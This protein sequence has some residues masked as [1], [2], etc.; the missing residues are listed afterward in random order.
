LGYRGMKEYTLSFDGF[1][2]PRTGLLGGVEGKGFKQLMATFESARI[3]T[4]ARAVGLARNALETA[5]A[6]ALERIQ[7]GKPLFAFPRVVDKLVGMAVEIM[8]ARRSEERR[9]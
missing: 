1:V 5:L 9:G 8:V 6:Y 2:V 7:F 3:Q 4:A